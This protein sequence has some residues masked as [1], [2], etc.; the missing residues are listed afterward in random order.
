MVFISFIEV[1]AGFDYAA[2]V[3]RT[4]SDKSE[5]PGRRTPPADR[6]DVT[7]ALKLYQSQTRSVIEDRRD[8]LVLLFFNSYE[9]LRSTPYSRRLMLAFE[10]SQ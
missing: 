9:T 1:R 3:G 7:K 2:N 6:R 5:R 8:F 10:T 4:S